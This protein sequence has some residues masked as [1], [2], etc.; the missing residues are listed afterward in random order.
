[1]P[2]QGGLLRN[3]NAEIVHAA[4]HAN[5]TI[6]VARINIIATTSPLSFDL[7]IAVLLGSTISSLMSALLNKKHS[8]SI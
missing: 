5:V 6:A 4:I 7:D 8:Y 1:L 2:Y 3:T